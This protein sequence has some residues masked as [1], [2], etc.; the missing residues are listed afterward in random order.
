LFGLLVVGLVVISFF[1]KASTAVTEQMKGNIAK[2]LGWG[3]VY[4]IIIPITAFVLLVT[5]IGAPL[6]LITIT[7]Y[8]IALYLS[9]VFMG[10]LIGYWILQYLKKDKKDKTVPLMWAMILGIVLLT[11]LTII[12]YFGLFIG[13]VATIWGLGALL[14]STKKYLK[15]N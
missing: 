1:K 3:L 10:L 15:G 14:E 12:P 5:I 8:T 6:A 9:K 7:L 4:L 2:N 11:V 13:F